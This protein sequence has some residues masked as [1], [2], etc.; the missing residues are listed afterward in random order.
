M[1]KP[2]DRIERYVIESVLGRGGMG[3]VYEA[4]DTR[5]GR[6]VALKLLLLGDTDASARQRMEREARAAA[7]FEH[8][9]AVVVYDVG[10]AEGSTYLAMELVRGRSMRAFVGDASIP[11]G[12]RLRW[13]CDVARALGAAHR[14]GLVH[15]D[16]KP[17]NV[18][19]REDGA[20]KVLDFGIAK[21]HRSSVDPTAP[22]EASA[23]S[24]GTITAQGVVVGTPL[25]S[26]PEQLRSDAIDG[27]VDQFAWGV[28][29][30]ELL[31]GAVPWR[32]DADGVALLAQILSSEPA[33]LAERAPGVAEP[34]AAAI[35]RALRKRAEDRFPTID[36]AADAIEPFADAATVS[37]ASR[38]VSAPDATRRSGAP[39][40]K[41]SRPVRIAKGTARVFFWILASIGGL[42]VGA[43]VI[44]AFKGTLTINRDRDAGGALLLVESLRC[45]PAELHG[46][47][48]SPELARAIGIGAC[49]R[50]ATEV[51][52]DWSAA[53]AKHSLTVTAELHGG[54]AEV[55]LTVGDRTAGARGPTPLDA[56]TAAVTELGKQLTAPPM[57]PAVIAG[58]GAGNPESAR[59]IERVWRRMI[60]GASPDDDAEISRLLETDPDSPWPHAFAALVGMR[61][62]SARREHHEAA[63]ARLDRLPQG[64][65]H[66]LRGILTLQAAPNER[67]EALRLL[68]QAYVEAPDDTDI[69]GLYA[70][71]SIGA[72]IPDE[73][74]G[75]VDRLYARAPTRSIVPLR[76]AV[77][78]APHRD[79]DRDKRY[80]DRLQE[81]LPET[82][83]WDV[84]IRQLVL[85]GKFVDARAALAFGRRVG[86]AGAS[87]DSSNVAGLLAW[88]EL[89]ALEPRA[90]RDAASAMYGD[91]R[92][93]VSTAGAQWTIA[94]YF[95]EG[96]IDEGEEALHRESERQ[97]GAG[98]ALVASQQIVFEMGARR[99]L[100]RPP[101]PE[102]RLAFVEK[103][104]ASSNELHPA[105]IARGRAE[106][107][108]ARAA[109]DPRQSKPLLEAALA[110]VEKL[111]DPGTGEERTTRD[112]ILVATVP[113]V[114][115]LRGTA[116]A[117]ARWTETE[118]APFQLRRAVALDGALALEASGDRQAAERAY[119]L[120]MDPL[121]IEWHIVQAMVA[122]V[123][124][125]ELYR[126]SKRG[127]EA[128]ALDAEVD[129]A[130]A[131]ADPALRVAILK[132]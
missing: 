48:M 35:T 55:E 122:R 82:L 70:A 20:V 38:E 10:E 123:R 43:I 124:L 102:P 28:M 36:A 108:L 60:L 87:A 109:L 81:T 40:G 1:R 119:R 6:R 95:A 8:P 63:L 112:G 18:M 64:R 46:E 71:A 103:T 56:I 105:S 12:R 9:N 49:A 93:Q 116:A 37:G 80:V 76:N 44:G 127:A 3:E 77:L 120:A 66:G 74:F 4:H 34:V 67:K 17:D 92:A 129:R 100:G 86:M 21:R 27:R 89:A 73:G 16:V 57:T 59:R 65:A 94:S 19:I 125:A 54:A 29:A 24:M 39:T 114:R 88:V 85:Q 2:G 98:S 106:L 117:A 42:I 22:T 83:A 97:Q 115:A 11:T 99:W 90:A 111:A 75:A 5:L 113:L 132:L 79:L 23:D 84:S 33:P 41:A 121:G 118:R 52:V 30:Y 14:A 110:E 13:L 26:A 128:A 7:A 131:K 15:R 51:G 45:E 31:T 101:A 61:G 69:T 62:T 58:W 126:A 25:Y 47:G 50:L 32:T 53:Q 104:L 68:R 96:R 78:A 130:W 72:G 107:A 91:P